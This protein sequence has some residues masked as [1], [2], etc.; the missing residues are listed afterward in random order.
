MGRLL[1]SPSILSDSFVTLQ[2][3]A[4]QTPL[5]MGLPRQEYWRGLLFPSPGDV[6]N[7]EIELT[8]P[9]VAGGFFTTEPPG[10]A[11]F[12]RSLSALG[13]RNNRAESLQITE[14]GK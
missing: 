10:E 7:P 3:V 12:P 1:F 11:Q 14:S 2:T 4:H 6:P 8:S 9:E 5:S 13:F